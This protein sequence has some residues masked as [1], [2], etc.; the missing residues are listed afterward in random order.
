MHLT[1]IDAGT[2]SFAGSCCMMH[3]LLPVKITE[4]TVL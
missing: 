2:L 4:F 1:Q 3:D